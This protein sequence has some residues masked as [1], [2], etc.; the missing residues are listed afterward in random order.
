MRSAKLQVPLLFRACMVTSRSST[1]TSFVRKSAPMVALYWLLNFLFTY[2]FISDVL[3]TLRA[4]RS[5]RRGGVS[6]AAA[7]AAAAAPAARAGGGA[8][9]SQ[10]RCLIG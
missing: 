2:W 10:S 8:R 3:P 4:A 6:A 1:C 5:K 9:C 7:A